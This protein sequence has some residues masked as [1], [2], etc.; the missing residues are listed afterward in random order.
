MQ[1]KLTHENIDYIIYIYIF[2]TPIYQYIESA[3]VAN[4]D[5]SYFGRPLNSNNW[6]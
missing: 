1:Q 3:E 2:R 4:E 6:P 5:A